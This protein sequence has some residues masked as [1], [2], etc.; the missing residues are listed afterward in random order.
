[1]SAKVIFDFGR[2]PAQVEITIGPR[3]DKGGLRV[4][5]LSRDLLHGGVWGKNGKYANTCWVTR[6][7]FF[8][9][10]IHVIIGN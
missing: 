3:R 6:K 2:E 10:R 9:E 7:K 1:M 5:I 4:F 8:R